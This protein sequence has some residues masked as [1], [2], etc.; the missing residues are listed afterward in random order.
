MPQLIDDIFFH[1]MQFMEI[2]NVVS[3]INIK[4]HYCKYVT[5]KY[6]A[7]IIASK[8]IDDFIKIQMDSLQ[9]PGLSI[10]IINNGKIVYHN[11]FGV[12]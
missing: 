2:S 10:A 1:I 9:M 7:T 8:E 11:A 12:T 4:K 6:T 5:K 3:F